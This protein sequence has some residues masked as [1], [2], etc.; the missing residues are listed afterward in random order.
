MAVS[1][2]CRR[3]FFHSGLGSE[4]EA[5]ETGPGLL[6]QSPPLINGHEHGYFHASLCYNLGAF[7]QAR[8]KEFAKP[9]PGYL[10]SPCVAHPV[11]PPI[12][13]CLDSKLAKCH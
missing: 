5:L 11:F 7:G 12:Q 10:Y 9:R 4:E 3:Q 13:E 1:R 2:T 6:F 8:L